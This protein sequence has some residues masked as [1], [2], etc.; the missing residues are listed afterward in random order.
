ML[1][2]SSKDFGDGCWSLSGERGFLNV[3]LG[4]VCVVKP[5][6]WVGLSVGVLKRSM[7]TGD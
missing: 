2:G 7:R 6:V 5:N 1:N 4:F 3:C